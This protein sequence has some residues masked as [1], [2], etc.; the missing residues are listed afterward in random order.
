LLV[1]FQI[2]LRE[3][4]D[5][6]LA[7]RWLLS[8]GIAAL[9]L[10]L[11]SRQ[12][13]LDA[14]LCSGVDLNGATLLCM[15]DADGGATL[16]WSLNLV[17]LLGAFL[18]LCLVHFLRV[19]R[20]AP[21]LSPLAKFD[22]S[23]LNR[24]GAVSFMAVFIFPLRLGEIA[25]PFLISKTGRVRKSA[26]F[27][28]IA[29]ERVMDG[30]MMALLLAL[31]LFFLPG[32]EGTTYVSLRAG[33]LVALAV[34]TCALML[35]VVAY[36]SKPHAV[37]FVH[38]VAGMVSTRLADRLSGMMEAFIDG[39]K[40]MPSASSFFRFLLLTMAY[41]GINGF[42][43]YLM[44]EAFGLTSLI[45]LAGAYAMMAAV[46]VGMM[47]PNSPANVGSF[48]YFLLLP[49]ALYGVPEAAGTPL[50]FALAVWAVM[51]LQYTLFAGFFL[52]TG[53]VSL[54]SIWSLQKEGLA[55]H[56]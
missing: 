46:A 51:L 45:D 36:L 11:S 12:W 18:V 43:Y 16:S 2:D 44:A 40:A 48:W 19:L 10:W 49:V 30:L 22:F 37:R 34:F 9:F 55:D 4:R 31:V 50:A 26:A 52:A 1:S 53:R 7:L 39:L 14:V 29:V 23:T 15:A 27:G 33:A 21:L 54:D 32:G 17:A 42:Y 28:T 38:G 25:R 56:E 35:L 8:L 6:K 47:I 41:W 20:W 5:M 24:V 3:A 13:P